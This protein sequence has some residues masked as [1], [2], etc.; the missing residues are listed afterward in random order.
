MKVLDKYILKNY[1]TPLITGFALF[2]F[3]FLMSRI[4]ELL[5]LS[6]TRGISAGYTG[7]IFL[8]SLP[9]LISL[10]IPMSHVFAGIM[11]FGRFANG[12]ETTAF[13][14]LGINFYRLMRPLFYFTVIIM[15]L[16]I[17]F[18]N[19][20]LPNSN[21]KLK[22]L[23][24]NIYKF[25][26]TYQL[27][28][29]VFIKDFGPY[30]FF[31]EKINRKND[32]MKNIYIYEEEN[33]YVKRIIMARSGKIIK[34]TRGDTLWLLLKNGTIHDFD[35][36][37]NE[38]HIVD[39]KQQNFVLPF[40]E[41]ISASKSSYRGD[42]ELDI[43]QLTERIRT[44]KKQMIKSLNKHHN[45]FLLIHY[46]RTLDRLYLEIYKKISI[47]LT[48]IFL[49]FLGAAIGS[50]MKNINIGLS[51]TISLGVYGV[52]YVMMIGGEALSSR[53]ILNPLLAS[54]IP[55]IVFGIATII[56]V[57]YVINKYSLIKYFVKRKR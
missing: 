16:L 25:K 47:P 45:K 36:Y 38:Y 26:P 40:K 1:I 57:S 42:H 15:L 34:G 3:I 29:G 19:T 43:W 56:L 13:K 24:I 51:L 54:L 33:G 7:M 20:V 11:T 18:N 50:L 12:N 48:S 10:T 32:A 52:F 39:F 4:F 44:T 41:N 30:S 5:D 28:E 21:H 22:N 35:K 6:I 14:S 37:H 46:K 23:M 27:E 8:T 49:L 31:I 17:V 9:Y 53:G 55:L 2:T